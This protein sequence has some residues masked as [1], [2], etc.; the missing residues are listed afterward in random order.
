MDPI[1]LENFLI[2]N[3][4]KGKEFIIIQKGIYM[5]E[6]GEIIHFKDMEYICFLMERNMKVGFRKE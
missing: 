5:L 6:I 2:I 4:D 3:K 1:I